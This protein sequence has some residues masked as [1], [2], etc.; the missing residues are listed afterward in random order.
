LGFNNHVHLT[1][2]RMRWVSTKN[3]ALSVRSSIVCNTDRVQTS[4]L[5]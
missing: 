5:T 2:Q 3:T 4:S 1:M